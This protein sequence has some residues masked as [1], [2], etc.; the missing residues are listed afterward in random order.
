MR[1]GK[2][3]SSN[4]NGSGTPITPVIHQSGGFNQFGLTPK[5]VKTQKNLLFNK[6][7]TP[8]HDSGSSGQQ[9]TIRDG[10]VIN[11]TSRSMRSSHNRNK[12][13]QNARARMSM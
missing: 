7:T 6:I 2:R 1:N 4:S 8:E 9:N 11:I 13:R 10:S 3:N 5:S 12:F